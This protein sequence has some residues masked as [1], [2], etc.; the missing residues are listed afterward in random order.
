METVELR[1]EKDTNSKPAEQ[2]VR[3][4]VGSL[5]IFNLPRI[6]VLEHFEQRQRGAS[7]YIKSLYYT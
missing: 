4:G 2:T 6:S 1:S 3:S 7:Q 5:G